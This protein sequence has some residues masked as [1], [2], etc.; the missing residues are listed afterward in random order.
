MHPAE[1][2]VVKDGMI[3]RLYKL[4]IAGLQHIRCECNLETISSYKNY[5]ILYDS[6]AKNYV[7]K[8]TLGI[9]LK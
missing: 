7:I 2:S 5:N 1:I 9:I 4:A 3:G 8:H 6:G